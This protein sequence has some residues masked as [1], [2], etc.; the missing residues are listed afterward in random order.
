MNFYRIASLALI[1]TICYGV[2]VAK[3]DEM[4]INERY[5]LLEKKRSERQ[6]QMKN[7]Q[8]ELELT[9]AVREKRSVFGNFKKLTQDSDN[10]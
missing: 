3:A 10:E 7:L 4:N 8:H 2:A 6:E 1:V 5:A 9:T